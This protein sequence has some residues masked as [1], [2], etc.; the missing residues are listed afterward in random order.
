MRYRRRTNVLVLVAILASLIAPA[1]PAAAADDPVIV[2]AGDIGD[3]AT[4]GDEAT[5]VLLDGI[6]GTVV[7][8]GD[9]A[10]P[11]G[12]T[13]NFRDCYA[14]TW[15][16]H[17][18]RTR[19]AVGN[20]EYKTTSAATPYFD[21]FGTAAGP[22]GKGWYSYDVGAWH[23]VVLN[24]NCAVIGGCGPSSAQITWLKADLAANSGEHV[25]AYWHHPRYSSGYHGNDL[26]VQTFWEVLYAAGAEIVL[27]GHD[28]SYERFA[29]QDPWA[30]ADAPFGIREF[31]VGTGGTALRPKSRNVPNSE[32]FSATHGVL[33]LT[34]RADGYDWAFV[35]IAG[36]TF[37]DAGS[38]STH[39]APP[40]RTRK[41]FIATGDTWVDQ[42][43]PTRN[44]GH[45]TTLVVD[46][47]T[48]NGKDAHAYIKVKVTDL[49]GVIDRVACRIWVTDATRDGPT[50]A[51]T[52]TG[53]SPNA[54]TWNNRPAPIGPAVSDLGSAAAG[55]WVEL[56]VT[57]LVQRAG[58]FGFVLKPT[59]TD[60]IDVSSNQGAHPPHLV[61]D[62]LPSS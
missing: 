35:P 28:H 46:G 22:R 47:D 38:G 32:V 23:V 18:A 54:L 51:P 7:A 44:Y 36:K 45:S 17:K 49:S 61:V 56:D 3:C 31:V 26:G 43:H 55:G 10:Y 4:S 11:D 14:P 24:S 8:L 41:A 25:L 62:T 12:T 48:G 5:A 60:G 27:N 6:P 1:S 40:P 16:R 50:I 42:A 15:G 37:T 39:G 9:I 53:W 2:A 33:Q 58:T 34:L 29:P 59:S 30:R 57:S 52:T 13:A 20:H 21:Y 19:P